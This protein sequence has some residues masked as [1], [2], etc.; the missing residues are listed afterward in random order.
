MDSE[1]LVAT[2]N[3]YLASGAKAVMR[4]TRFGA[5]LVADSQARF[6]AAV[7]RGN[8]YIASTQAGVA[9]TAGLAAATVGF[10][11]W[12]P[13]GSGKELVILEV[14]IAP[15]TA[16]AGIA[17]FA[18]SAQVDPTQAEPSSISN[19]LTIRNAKLRANSAPVAKAAQNATL[20]AAPVV[21]RAIGGGPVATGSVNSAN[22]QEKIDGGIIVPEG[23]ALVISC[24]TTGISAIMS[25]TFEE[26]PKTET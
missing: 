25:V 4:L 14:N 22:I 12:N 11:L 26:V 23:C 8:V 24:F 5:A 17:T 1:G 13:K 6:Q 20:G 9:I 19:T 3:E 7:Q 21:I 10:I 16:P 15:S 18:L 2:L